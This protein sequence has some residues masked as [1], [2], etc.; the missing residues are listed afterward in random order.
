LYVASI[1]DY[2]SGNVYVYTYPQGHLAGT[3]T[4]S[5]SPAGEC[6]DSKGDVFIVALANKSSN[7]S[8]IY[9]Y[10]H[11][12]TQPIAT[13]NDPAR[14]D[15]CAIDLAS[16]NL[17]VANSFD[18]KNPYGYYGDVAVYAG[19]QGNPTMYYSSGLVGFGLC[20]YDAKENLYLRA[21]S[22]QYGYQSQLIRLSAD[23]DFE[24]ISLT[25]TLYNEG[26][27]P[28]VQW[29]GKYMTVSSTAYNKPTYLYRLRIAGDSAIVVGTTTLRSKRNSLRTGQFW[30]QGK[31]VV[32]SD[33]FKGLG[34]VDL[35]PYPT[36]GKPRTI[37]PNKENFEPSGIAVSPAI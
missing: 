8:I 9:E 1:T 22:S 34:G 26:D 3:L 4:G 6:V 17:A 28:S 13:L 30:I 29:D 2:P 7:S 18:S 36:T 19:A 12:G 5:I 24:Q 16:G 35:W 23:G 33:Y 25:V 31:R 15:G 10:A 21:A 32:G 11:G 14:G 20:G 37:V 27:S